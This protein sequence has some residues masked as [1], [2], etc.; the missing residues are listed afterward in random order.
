M[1]KLGLWITGTYNFEEAIC[2]LVKQSKE[3]KTN[4][5]QMCHVYEPVYVCGDEGRVNFPVALSS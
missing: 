4:R 2:V 1:K 5:H 3:G